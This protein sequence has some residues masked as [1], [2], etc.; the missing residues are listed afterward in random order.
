MYLTGIIQRD[1]SNRLFSVTLALIRVV[2]FPKGLVDRGILRCFMSSQATRVV[3]K[4]MRYFGSKAF[5]SQ[6]PALAA[7]FDLAAK[8]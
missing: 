6:R 7:M 3:L 5:G 8:V 1:P 4:S 2:A